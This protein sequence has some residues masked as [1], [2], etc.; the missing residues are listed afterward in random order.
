MSPF[1][2]SKMNVFTCTEILLPNLIEKVDG[3]CMFEIMT[4]VMATFYTR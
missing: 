2:F 1:F 3:Y 4:V